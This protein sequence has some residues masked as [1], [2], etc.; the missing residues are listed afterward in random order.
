MPSVWADNEEVVF[1]EGVP[2]DPA[3]VYNLLMEALSEQSRVGSK[4]LGRWSRFF[5]QG[6]F[7][8]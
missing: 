3:Q 5:G 7:Q 2:S 4:F 1:G 8:K 6:D